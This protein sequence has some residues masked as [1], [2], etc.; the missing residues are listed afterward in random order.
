MAGPPSPGTSQKQSE[1]LIDQQDIRTSQSP[2]SPHCRE[3]MA[4]SRSSPSYSAADSTGSS[5]RDYQHSTNCNKPE[6]AAGSG[7]LPAGTVSDIIHIISKLNDLGQHILHNHEMLSRST[8]LPWP[9]ARECAFAAAHVPTIFALRLQLVA[10]GGFAYY[11]S[12]D[13]GLIP[14]WSMQEEGSNPK[15]IMQYAKV[16]LRIKN[17]ECSHSLIEIF[18]EVARESGLEAELSV[19]TRKLCKVVSELREG[20]STSKCGR[21]AASAM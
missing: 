14:Q 17:R 1:V 3:K 6:E 12:F 10:L 21:R 13:Q 15:L 16:L 20:I 9:L 8:D 4:S 18:V 5:Q 7:N 11:D 19:A 2:R